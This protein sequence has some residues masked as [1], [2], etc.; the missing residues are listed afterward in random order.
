MIELSLLTVRQCRAVF[1]RLLRRA[2]V[3]GEP[4][5]SFVA[6][7]Y[8]LR[9]RLCHHGIQAELHQ[10]G[11]HARETITLPLKALADFEGKAGTVTLETTSTAMVQARWDD[12]RVPR[13]MDYESPDLTKLP[14]WPTVPDNLV[15]A[16]QNFVKAL[17][18]ASACTARDA[19]R[20]ATDK[21]QLR[22]QA[23]EIVATDGRQL[24]IQTGFSFPF[25]EDVLVPSMSV[26]SC[27]ELPTD[28][29][30][31]IGKDGQ[32]FVLRM[33]DWTL[34]L[35]IDK[36][37]RYPRVA[38]IV[39][40]RA[41]AQTQLHLAPED[42]AFVTRTLPRLPGADEEN[43]PITLDLNGQVA[44]RSRAEGQ[45]RVTEVVLAKSSTTGKSARFVANRDLLSRAVELG[46][47]Q[48]DVIDPDKP[49]LCQDATRKF[50]WMPL[51]KTGAIAPTD[52]ALRIVSAETAPSASTEP[53]RRSTMPIPTPTNGASS[54]G[55]GHTKVDGSTPEKATNSGIHALME[56]AEALKALLH[57]AYG[58][59]SQLLIA[60]KKH[61]KQS[62]VVRA[63]LAS[64]RQ[65]QQVAD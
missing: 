44:I 11:N 25:T 8:G 31:A 64:L 3:G 6:S 26:L 5:V 37:A 21:M 58:R 28:G 59:S 17:A 22:G 54:N 30:I 1:R 15:A 40:A 35:P 23:G 56:E 46:F 24:L 49:I 62:Q 60:L 4:A 43:S 38:D 2:L 63:T 53:I 51:G 10:P 57:D 19:I 18:D 14:A 32:N 16:D 27:R 65:L 39:P 41:R 36:D 42:A 52:D 48:F 47:M 61:R 13:V 29:P 50:V 45:S 9:V 33:G 12:A 20:Y 7:D 55:N 34:I